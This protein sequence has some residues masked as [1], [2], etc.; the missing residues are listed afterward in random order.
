MK[1]NHKNFDMDKILTTTYASLLNL[2]FEW[3]FCIL[4]TKQV[5]NWL[6]TDQEPSI[7]A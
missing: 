7:T 6:Y 3:S 1:I 2:Y 5:G 4:G